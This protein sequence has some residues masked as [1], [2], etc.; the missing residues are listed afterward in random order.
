M[1]IEQLGEGRQADASDPERLSEARTG[2]ST[3]EHRSAKTRGLGRVYPRGNVW[4]IQ[5]CFRGKVYRETSGS[6]KRSAA[7]ALLKKRFSEIGRGRLI[8]PVMERTTFKELSDM[9]IDDYT[10]NGRKSLRRANTSVQHLKDFFG[11]SWAIDITADRIAVYI[12]SR[13]ED[14][15][16]AA[17]PATI[18]NELAAL[19]RMFTLGIQAGKAAERPH[20]PSI[21]VRNTRTGFF[22][23][24]EFGSVLGHLPQHL[25][26][27]IEFAYLT[28]WR[29]GEVLTLS[30][31]QVDSDAG[32]V[33]LEPGTT[34]NDEGRTFPFT[35]L[36]ALAALLE[37]QREHTTACERAIGK[38]IT[39]VFHRKGKPIRDFRGSWRKACT[40]A[41]LTGRLVHDLRRTAV[42]NLERAGVPRSVAMKL[43]G[44]KTESVYRRYAIVSEADLSEG[45]RKLAT[46]HAS[47]PATSRSV[48]PI[49]GQR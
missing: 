45:V 43:T 22:E 24:A 37:E 44:H 27:V 41:G 12:R 29:I 26:A 23:E 14:E 47:T 48:I 30:W 10:I 25:A 5:Y 42:R 1:S 13:M 4:W 15:E 17:A 32:T 34:K 3:R 9:L 38:I 18:R 36:P 7:T 28:G 6:P 49:K 11:E 31:R 2:A 8:G 40:A 21:E 19:K 46:L 39:S 33:R 16:H 35:A 20:I